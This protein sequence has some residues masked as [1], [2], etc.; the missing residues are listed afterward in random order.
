MWQ[1][2]TTEAQSTGAI[3]TLTTCVRWKPRGRGR[4]N[5]LKSVC[6]FCVR[7]C[8]LLCEEVVCL[9]VCACGCAMSLPCPALLKQLSLCCGGQPCA[10]ARSAA[11]N[12]DAL[13]YSLTSNTKSQNL[14]TR[15]HV[16]H[17]QACLYQMLSLHHLSLFCS[18][19]WTQREKT[20][21]VKI[22]VCTDSNQNC[23]CFF[24]SHL[25]SFN[26]SLKH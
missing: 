8:V 7:V 13:S 10:A 12:T 22:Y 2:L 1:N 25:F 16:V 19:P 26:C 14:S 5:A 11:V 20:A 6:V 9:S 4:V 15:W 3:I 23:W 21:G 24:C 18:L 17:Y